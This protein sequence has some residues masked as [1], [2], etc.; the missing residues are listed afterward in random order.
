MGS[1]MVAGPVRVQRERSAEVGEVAGGEGERAGGDVLLEVGDG[2]GSR[3]GEDVGREGK[4]VREGDLGG[5]RAVTPRDSGVALVACRAL[6][7][8]QRAEGDERDA[9]PGGPGRV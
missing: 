9:F 3:D 1:G 8:A 5:G 7:A 6:P 2:A 4:R